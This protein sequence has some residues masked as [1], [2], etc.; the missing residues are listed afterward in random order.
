MAGGEPRGTGA[1]LEPAHA[2]EPAWPCE[3]GV[4]VHSTPLGSKEG[5]AKP[6]DLAELADT[7]SVRDHWSWVSTGVLALSL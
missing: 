5:T 2:P 6:R 1:R 4:F 3:V 7:L